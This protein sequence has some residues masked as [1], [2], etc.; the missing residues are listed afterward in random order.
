M[1]A[2]SVMAIAV[3]CKLVCVP[4]SLYN[5]SELCVFVVQRGQQSGDSS[6]KKN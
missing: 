1:E 3:L 6:P 5:P 4:S 2:V